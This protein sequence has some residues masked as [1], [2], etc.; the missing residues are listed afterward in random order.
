MSRSPIFKEVARADCPHRKPM[1][2]N[3]RITPKNRVYSVEPPS[4]WTSHSHGNPALRAS[5]VAGDEVRPLSLFGGQVYR[6]S[7]PTIQT[8]GS[9]RLRDSDDRETP[10]HSAR[11]AH[12]EALVTLF[13]RLFR[14][15]VAEP[16]GASS[17]GA[18]PPRVACPATTRRNR[19]EPPSTQAVFARGVGTNPV[20]ARME[21]PLP[22][23]WLRSVGRHARFPGRPVLTSAGTPRRRPPVDRYPVEAIFLLAG[24]TA[25]GP[26][27]SI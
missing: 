18:K 9:T 14:R 19:F 5:N 17:R 20:L 26:P 2:S 23:R 15:G 16:S 12:P 27:V 7:D 24:L 1:G 8:P 22:G 25:Q 13:S 10:F 6:V 11:L 21:R 3:D 4:H